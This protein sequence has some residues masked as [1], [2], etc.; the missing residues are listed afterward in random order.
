MGAPQWY[1]FYM[2][3]RFTPKFFYI[4]KTEKYK[5]VGQTTETDVFKYPGSGHKWKRHLSKLGIKS[6]ETIVW[7]WCESPEDFQKCLDHFVPI[8]Y[9]ESDEWANLK[10]E[11]P[12]DDTKGAK[13]SDE[14]K[15]NMKDSSGMLGKV[16]DHHPKFGYKMSKSAVERSRRTDKTEYS[17]FNFKDGRVFN[18]TR[19]GL[20]DFLSGT[21]EYCQSSISKMING[22]CKHHK[23]WKLNE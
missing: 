7:I 21:N 12:F 2:T 9:V 18:G 10:L 23:G 13:Y 4:K 3:N 8:D 15:Q 14:A 11:T 17:F 20:K 6:P 5:Y 1:K 16:G 22:D 19:L